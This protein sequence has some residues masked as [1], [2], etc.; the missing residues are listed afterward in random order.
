MKLILTAVPLGPPPATALTFSFKHWINSGSA[1]E[2]FGLANASKRLALHFLDQ[3]HSANSRCVPW[4]VFNCSM[5]ASSRLALAGLRSRYAVSSRAVKSSRDSITMDCWPL[6]VMI[7]GS[8]SLQTRSMVVARLAR[9]AEY[10]MA[11]P[12]KATRTIQ[13]LCPR[14]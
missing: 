7:W 2:R 12:S 3:L 10:E 11:S 4:P 1:I 8:W 13:P 9:A 6:R 14:L 5:A